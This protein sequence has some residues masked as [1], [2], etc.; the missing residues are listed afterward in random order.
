MKKK[1]ENLFMAIVFLISLYIGVQT[2][3]D[4]AT[5][6]IVQ[7]GA[8]TLPAGTLIFALSFTVRDLIHERL[9]KGWAKAAVI[10]AGIINVIQFL[11]LELMRHIPTAPF[12][13]YT[14]E[15]RDIFVVVP[16]ITIGSI[17]AEIVSELVDTEVY[18]L[19]ADKM[20]NAPKIVRVL[21][22]N[23]AALPVDSIV[24]L[25][26]A[27]V[28]LPPVFSGEPYPIRDALAL[29]VGQITYKAVVAVVSSPLIHIFKTEPIDIKL[30]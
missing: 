8:I 2:I 17:V 21:I 26:L 9:G 27:F 29:V 14:Q 18:Q 28:I 5:T 16:A 7:I 12:Y 24:F 6:L 11:Y 25:M 30:S 20:P 13:P 4:V 1:T 22:S 15:W 23:F 3:A 10:S 19:V